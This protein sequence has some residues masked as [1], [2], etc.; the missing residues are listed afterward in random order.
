V[1]GRDEVSTVTSAFVTMRARLQESQRRL[2]D[3]EQLA[4]IGRMSSTISHDLRRPL[5]AIQAYA[6]FLAERDLTDAQR[7]DYYG[8]LRAAVNRMMAEINALL[9]FS[10]QGEEIRPVEG[11]VMEIVDR[12]VRTMK[13]LPEFEAITVTSR[14]QGP[15]TG[16]F[17]QAKLERVLLNLLFNAGEALGSNPGR[18]DVSC[19]P[20]DG[21][22]E[23]QVA[24]TGPGIPAEIRDKLFQ[25]FVTYGKENGIGLGLTVVQSIVQQHGGEAVV[26]QTG[27]GG[28][29]FKISIPHVVGDVGRPRRRLSHEGHQD[30]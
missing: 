6:E 7:R 5:T 16:R 13:A 25:P 22:L 10:K 19:A 18:I 9:A 28:T 2:L 26:E 27:P 12:A 4:T 30:S 11:D 29:V 23:I 20:S 17:D 21:R 14:H 8:E 24:D 15:C 3:T 1:R